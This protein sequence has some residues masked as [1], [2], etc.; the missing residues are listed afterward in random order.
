[1]FKWKVE[2]EYRKWHCVRVQQREIT[3]MSSDRWMVKHSG[4]STRWTVTQ[5]WNGEM[6]PCMLQCTGTAKSLSEKKLGT[7]GHTVWWYFQNMQ[8]HVDRKHT[9]SCQEV[10]WG[11]GRDYGSGISF[12][13]IKTW[14]KQRVEVV[15]KIVNTFSFLIKM[16]LSH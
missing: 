1:M 5:L 12:Q 10:E 2:N 7:K 8:T 9:S 4:T 13:A 11:K 16:Y 6:L 15:I 3:W 14:G